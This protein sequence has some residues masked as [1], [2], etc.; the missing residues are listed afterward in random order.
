MYQTLARK[1]IVTRNINPVPRKRMNSGMSAAVDVTT[2]ML[3]HGRKIASATAERPMTAPSGMPTT[4]AAINPTAIWRS[5]A[6]SSRSM[7]P[8]RSRPT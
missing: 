8:C 2:N 5:D 3:T 7:S 4:Q 6:E 1:T